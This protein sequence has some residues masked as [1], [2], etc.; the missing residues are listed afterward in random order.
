M[1][2]VIDVQAK[3]RPAAFVPSIVPCAGNAAH[4][5][6]QSCF[7]P[8]EQF[9]DGRTLLALSILRTGPL[10]CRVV[11]TKTLSRQQ[12]PIPTL[13]TNINWSQ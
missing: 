10:D 6:L 11:D 5:A 7:F 9:P 3:A 8:L 2:F 4:A 12:G 1:G 13:A